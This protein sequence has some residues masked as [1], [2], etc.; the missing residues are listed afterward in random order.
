MNREIKG[1]ALGILKP[2]QA[3]E[4]MLTDENREHTSVSYYGTRVADTAGYVKG[5]Y[6]IPHKPELPTNPYLNLTNNNLNK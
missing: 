3:S 1:N 2:T 6:D 4:Q 5:A